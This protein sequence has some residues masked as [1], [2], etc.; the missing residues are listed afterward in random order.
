MDNKS[1]HNSWWPSYHTSV[2]SDKVDSLMQQNQELMNENLKLKYCDKITVL[3]NYLQ[4]QE[5]CKIHKFRSASIL[6][7]E[8][9]DEIY[10]LYDANFWEKI[11]RIVAKNLQKYSQ[12]NPELWIG[13]Y[14][15]DWPNYLI[16]YIWEVTEEFIISQYESINRMTYT[17]KK[18]NE[19]DASVLLQFSLWISLNQD[20]ENLLKEC[21]FA[22]KYWKK[23][24]MSCILF[25]PSM[26]TSDQTL[27]KHQHIKLVQRAFDE[28]RFYIDLQEI[29]SCSNSK[30]KVHEA[31]ARLKD[32]EGKNVSP[33]DF[34]SI[35]EL[36]GRNIEFTDII[37]K[38]VCSAMQQIEGRFNINL[39]E[40][41]LNTPW[42]AE[43][44][45]NLVVSNWWIPG[46]ITFEILESMK[47]RTE[48]MYKI[49]WELKNFW[50]QIA[51]DDFGHWFNSITEII[52]LRKYID[53]IKFDRSLMK[54]IDTNEDI[55]IFVRD[56][57]KIFKWRGMKIVAE[58]IE[59]ESQK[60]II[61]KLWVDIQW[62]L[63][64]KPKS[65]EQLIEE[66]RNDILTY[67]K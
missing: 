23:E 30:E 37:I 3:P 63:L 41:D 62:F 43:Q 54:D 40:T 66:I 28:E 47:L 58:W 34:L 35:I 67:S 17:F 65:L 57:V 24:K 2:N 45:Y 50:F 13:I 16:T 19:V 42:R 8:N 12:K 32:D 46:R 25:D 61:D 36:L 11:L 59:R 7:L 49:V 33:S 27:K 21:E 14:K 53:A 64:S 20:S 55:R 22:L 10:E 15:F 60:K 26:D 18:I 48:D 52:K 51:I 4:F 9:F 38:I 44:I 56:V 39:T 6:K 5:D 29:H 31:L 1:L